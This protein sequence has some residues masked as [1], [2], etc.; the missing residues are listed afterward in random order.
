MRT[1]ALLL[2]LAGLAAVASTGA[3]QGPD[4][5][6]ACAPDVEALTNDV[7]IPHPAAGAQFTIL[8]RLTRT[9]Q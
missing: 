8:T 3:A 2:L 5:L 7:R 4:G 1:S 9:L 6:L